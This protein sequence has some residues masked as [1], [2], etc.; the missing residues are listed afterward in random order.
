MFQILEPCGSYSFLIENNY[1]GKKQIVSV[2]PALYHLYDDKEIFTDL[3][4]ACPFF[5]KNPLDSLYYCTIHLTRPDVCQEYGCWRFLIR[6]SLG[7][8]AGRVMQSR[9][10]HADSPH[11]RQI[12]NLYVRTLHEADDDTWDRK[13]C[14]IVQKAG[15]EIRS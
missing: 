6:D 5:R 2:T 14:E 9:H 3:P 7:N 12:W 11:L 13:M 4:E 1:T 15:F 8:R 10:L